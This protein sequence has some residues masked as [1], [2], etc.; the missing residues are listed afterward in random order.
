MGVQQALCC[1]DDSEEF[2]RSKYM[3]QMPNQKRNSIHSINNRRSKISR[4]K[5]RGESDLNEER[6]DDYFNM[7]MPQIMQQRQQQKKPE[8]DEEQY[9]AIKVEA[10]EED[11]E[12]DPFGSAERNP[13]RN[14][15]TCTSVL[16]LAE[17]QR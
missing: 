7:K 14:R 6:E 12:E 15:A 5:P 8:Q 3:S 10:L 17:H 9:V 13:F 11:Q 16:S 4:E 1:A 2:N